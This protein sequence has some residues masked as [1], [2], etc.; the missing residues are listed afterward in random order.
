MATWRLAE[1]DVTGA[2]ATAV[3]SIWRC[4]TAGTADNSGSAILPGHR[5]ELA[6]ALLVPLTDLERHP[7]RALAQLLGVLPPRW[8]GP[9]SPQG[10]GPPRSPG[11]CARLCPGTTARVKRPVAVGT[12]MR[13]ISTGNVVRPVPWANCPWRPRDHRRRRPGGDRRFQGGI[14]RDQPI[15]PVDDEHAPDDLGGDYQPQLDAVD[16]STLVGTDH[17]VR[18]GVIARDCRSHIRD[19]RGGSM[20]DDQQQFFADLASIG[21]IDLLRKG[22]DRLPAHPPYGVSWF[23]VTAAN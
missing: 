16:D 10:S 20:V 14:D 9:A 4:Y 13:L 1:H 17:S 19:Q 22:N 11:R 18:T 6:T 2:A 5:G 21:H 12:G 15:Y 3:T 7:D 23:L 8:H